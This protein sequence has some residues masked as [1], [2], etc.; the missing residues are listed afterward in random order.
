[1]SYC[2]LLDRLE[3]TQWWLVCKLSSWRRRR[4]MSGVWDSHWKPAAVW[5]WSLRIT[6]CCLLIFFLYPCV[7]RL[8][9]VKFSFSH[10]SCL[11]SISLV[12]C[13][14]E[15]KNSKYIF[16]LNVNFS[17]SG[18]LIQLFKYQYVICVSCVFFSYYLKVF[19]FTDQSISSLRVEWELQCH[20]MC[21]WSRII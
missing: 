18:I 7:E 11:F 15:K 21:V 16:L 2:F 6:R 13:R 5:R 14:K 9:W 3:I 20:L 17:L 4:K 12:A 10:H 19:G 8:S 1:M